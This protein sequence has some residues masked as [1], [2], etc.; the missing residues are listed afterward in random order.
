MIDS[1]IALSRERLV[2]RAAEAIKDYVV[3]NE[4]QTND[5]LP[6]EN[7]FAQRLQVS[8][9]VVRQALSSLEAVGIVRTE[10]G[11][12]TFVADWYNN[13]KLFQ[14][15]SLWQDLGNLDDGRYFELRLGFESG[16]LQLVMEKA[17]DDDFDRLDELARWVDQEP[18]RRKTITRIGYSIKRS[19]IRLRTRFW[20][21]WAWFS[22]GIC[23]G[24]AV[25]RCACSAYRMRMWSE[26]IR[27]SLPGFVSVTLLSFP[28]L[29]LS[30][31]G[32]LRSIPDVK[33]TQ[34]SGLRSS[35]NAWRTSHPTVC[36]RFPCPGLSA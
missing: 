18:A 34:L 17:T 3:R 4:L 6:S 15:L 13:E 28:A 36:P 2:D 27:C 14:N 10:H 32:I 11:R 35:G 19:W 26:C 29:S 5:R 25:P 8:R 12:G 33:R 23:F 24:Y 21:P 1:L 22:P 31:S 9:N 30:I 7:E 20:P 16:I